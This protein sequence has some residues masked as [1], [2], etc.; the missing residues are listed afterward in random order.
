VNVKNPLLDKIGNP[1]M[2]AYWKLIYR[3]ISW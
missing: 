1:V 2:D 3:F